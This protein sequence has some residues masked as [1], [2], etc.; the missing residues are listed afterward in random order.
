MLLFSMK[1]HMSCNET[2]IKNKYGRASAWE[3]RLN[4]ASN[5]A[6]TELASNTT[7]CNTVH[8]PCLLVSFLTCRPSH[9]QHDW[10]CCFIKQAVWLLTNFTEHQG[11]ML[12]GNNKCTG[13]VCGPHDWKDRL[14][15]PRYC[16]TSLADLKHCMQQFDLNW[17]GQ[18]LGDA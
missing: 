11:C 9:S 4:L 8:V 10:S 3:L 2:N 12:L 13:W 18:P 16:S 14:C 15:H 1:K 7:E 6:W 5:A 17:G